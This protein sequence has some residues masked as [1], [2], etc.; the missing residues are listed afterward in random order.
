MGLEELQLTL[1]ERIIEGLKLS[2]EV[3]IWSL[4]NALSPDED[5]EEELWDE[6]LQGE[7]LIS[8]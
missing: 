7:P 4:V 8:F 1:A 2:R 3:D 6:L 5:A